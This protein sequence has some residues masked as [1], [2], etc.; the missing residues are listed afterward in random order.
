MISE[1]EFEKTIIKRTGRSIGKDFGFILG[2]KTP[3]ITKRFMS[4]SKIDGFTIWKIDN[5][6]IIEHVIN[7]IN[8]EDSMTQ[9]INFLN[10]NTN[11]QDW[12]F[13]FNPYT[14]LW[15]GVKRDNYKD[16]FNN[17]ESKNVLRSKDINTL[18]AL[19][20][21]TNGDAAEIQKL[22]K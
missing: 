21:K 3:F 22:L 14:S 4:S 7:P 15:N 18:T 19:I 5:G 1:I 16:L 6:I 9:I 13:N 8:I 2:T 10:M 12:V 20:E 17:N 11:L